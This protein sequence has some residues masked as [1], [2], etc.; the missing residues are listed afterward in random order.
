[1]SR[2]KSVST[3]SARNIVRRYRQ[4]LRLR[5]AVQLAERSSIRIAQRLHAGGGVKGDVRLSGPH[6]A[7]PLE[8]TRSPWARWLCM[9]RDPR[10]VDLTNLRLA[11]AIFV[12]RLDAFE[13]RIKA[14][15]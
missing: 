3:P 5:E 2:Q 9:N 1:M 4:L 10:A 15:R 11:L 14:G 13:T 8:I 7:P 12:V 6:F